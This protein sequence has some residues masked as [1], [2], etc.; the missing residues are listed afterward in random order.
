MVL[1]GYG[2]TE[3][4]RDIESRVIEDGE[5]HTWTHRGFTF[6]SYPGTFSDGSRCMGTRILSGP[7]EKDPWLYTMK[8]TGRSASLKE[9]FDLALKASEDEPTKG[10]PSDI[11]SRRGLTDDATGEGPDTF[12]GQSGTPTEG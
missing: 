6:Q 8:K 7:P 5:T 1:E 2:E 4:P 11:L 10:V 9:A 3:A 12:E